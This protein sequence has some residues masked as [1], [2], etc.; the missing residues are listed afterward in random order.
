[1]YF[2]ELVWYS[3]DRK[4]GE[5]SDFKFAHYRDFVSNYKNMIRITGSPGS[6]LR[7]A[8]LRQVL[9]AKSQQV[10]GKQ[11]THFVHEL[12]GVFSA[13]FCE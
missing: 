3:F 10:Y 5:P 9:C 11:E 8:F 2:P 13:L 12:E 7:N 1:M 6:V 4:G